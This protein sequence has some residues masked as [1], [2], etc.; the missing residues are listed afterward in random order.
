MASPP[1]RAAGFFVTGTLALAAVGFAAFAVQWLV[2]PS[3]MAGPLGIVLQ[4]GDATSDARAVYGG[5]ELGLAAFLSYCAM[6]AARRTLGLTAATFAMLGLGLARLGGVLVAP[7]GVT[8]ATHQLLG[9]DFGGAA[10]CA[11]ALWVSRS[12]HR[13]GV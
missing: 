1:S 12:L 7:E 3:A 5:L 11:V 4:N 9:T 13:S 2:H 10:L 8:G 6:S